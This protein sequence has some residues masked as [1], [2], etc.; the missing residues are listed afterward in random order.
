VK[1]K[2]VKGILLR[3]PNKLDYIIGKNYRI[4]CLLNY[5]GKVVE[6]VA[7]EIIAK[8]Y[9]RLELLYNG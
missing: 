3:K 1:W 5:I 8:L 6:K 4:I 7:A 9:E 2:I